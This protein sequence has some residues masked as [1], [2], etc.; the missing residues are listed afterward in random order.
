M[1]GVFQTVLNQQDLEN[2][3]RTNRKTNVYLDYLLLA[4]EYYGTKK[5]G[6]TPQTVEDFARRTT[7]PL[8]IMKEEIKHYNNIILLDKTSRMT[9]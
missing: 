9:L 6:I 8:Q 3:Q 1:K 2:W 4:A 7:I 5:S